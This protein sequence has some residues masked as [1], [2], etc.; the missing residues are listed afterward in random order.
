MKIEKKYSVTIALF[1][2]D[3][4]LDGYWPW[5]KEEN[6]L[7][8][9]S[10]S[11]ALY[12]K[13]WGDDEEDTLEAMEAYTPSDLSPKRESG[14]LD[15]QSKDAGALISMV[16]EFHRALEITPERES[17]IRYLERTFDPTEYEV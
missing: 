3:F 1:I 6:N 2:Q 15:I 7:I 11:F 9:R 8:S 4:L 17:L 10:A 16:N 12:H 5:C 13:L 14:R